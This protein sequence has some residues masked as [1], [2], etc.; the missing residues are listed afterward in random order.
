MHIAIVGATGEVGRKMI[1]VLDE[2][3]L[4]VTQLSL[5]ASERSAG[6]KLFFRGT[7]YTV[8]EANEATI[9]QK[10]TAML[11][12]A[13][14]GTAIQYGPLA[15]AAGNTVIDNSSAFR[16]FT[17]VPLV[18]PQI[19]GDLLNGYRGLVAN[20]NCSTIQ[21]VLALAPLDKAYNL[22]KV[23]VST[24]QSVSGAGHKGLATLELQEQGGTRPGAFTR[25][26]HRN[27]IPQIGDWMEDGYCTEE[28]KMRYET[29]KIMRKKEIDICPTVVR[30]PVAYGHSES[31]Y[32]EFANP[33]PING[34]A[35]AWRQMPGLEYLPDDFITP[36]QLGE[37]DSSYVCRLRYGV[38]GSSIAFW[39]VAHN[40]R[41]G[42]A[43]NAVR[44]L[45]SWLQYNHPEML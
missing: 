6:Q 13:G 24:Y 25:A 21:M 27:V 42:A 31:I 7:D 14:S 16:R 44:I 28:D 30:V 39:N 5:F 4:K 38:N 23:V 10:Y 41:L 12:S 35:Q 34:V 33:C 26:I 1:Q 15:A 18:V 37:S 2:S 43:T 45:Q 36:A 8:A 3:G 20:P 29:R 32:C 17:D 19:N 22:Q 11:F 40:V 9:Q